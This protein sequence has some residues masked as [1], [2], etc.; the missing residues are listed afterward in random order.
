MPKS[1]QKAYK[2]VSVDGDRLISVV[3]RNS[4]TCVNYKVGRWA[5]PKQ[6]ACPFLFVFNT[7]AA[8]R[9]FRNSHIWESLVIYRCEV[10]NMTETR[11]GISIALNSFKDPSKWPVGTRFADSVKLIEKIS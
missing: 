11:E 7:R 4:S 9:K 3:C 8:A 1:I 5:N 10:K 6:G 2:V